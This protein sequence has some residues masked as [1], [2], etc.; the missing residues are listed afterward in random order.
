MSSSGLTGGSTTECILDS[1]IKS[2]N[3]EIDMKPEKYCKKIVKGSGSNF[4]YAFFFLSKRKRRAIYAIYAFSRVIDDIVDE[5]PEMAAKERLL[6]FWRDEID[7]CYEGSSEHPLT[8]E[9]NYAV[10][11]F[12]IPKEYMVDHLNGIMQDMVQTRY[13]TFE[14]LVHYCYRVASIVGLICLKI[15]EVEDNGENHTAAVNLGLAFQTTNILRDVAS[16]SERDRIYIPKED[17]LRFHLTEDDILQKR[18]TDEFVKLMDF[19]WE[20]A[21][22]FFNKALTGF[23]KKAARKLLPAMVMADIYY[24]ILMEIRERHYNVFEEKIRVP[25]KEKLRMAI[26]RWWKMRWG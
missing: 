25:N 12:G 20:R 19:E 9:L 26:R 21:N 8:K 16:D 15:F 24:K 10:T 13:A 22:D 18:Y 1:P 23:D 2:E 3:D 6:A 4:Y 17:L 11:T 5:E 14:D 7:R